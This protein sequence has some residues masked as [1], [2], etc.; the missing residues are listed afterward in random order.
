MEY[1]VSHFI[2]TIKSNHLDIKEH[3]YYA[4]KR[5]TRAFGLV[6]SLD[7]ILRLVIAFFFSD[8]R[9]TAKCI[10]VHFPC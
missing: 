3:F 2:I 10:Y 4:R 1:F 6:I 9:F 8:K 7:I 5:I